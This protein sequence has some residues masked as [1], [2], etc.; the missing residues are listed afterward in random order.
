MKLTSIAPN[1][2]DSVSK[3]RPSLDRQLRKERSDFE[4]VPGRGVRA[5]VGSTEALIGNCTLRRGNDI[6]PAPAEDALERLKEE[7]KPRCASRSTAS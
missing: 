1:T 5:T 4:N 2:L 7:G 3:V 6:D